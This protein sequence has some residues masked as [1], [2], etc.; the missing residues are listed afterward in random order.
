[1]LSSCQVLRS[2]VLVSNT[3]ITMPYLIFDLNSTIRLLLKIHLSSLGLNTNRQL[4]TLWLQSSR[5]SLRITRGRTPSG[6]EGSSGSS[7]GECRGVA[8]LF[9]LTI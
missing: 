8:G 2:V 3:Y 9:F 5:R 7:Q 4:T 6:P 1:M